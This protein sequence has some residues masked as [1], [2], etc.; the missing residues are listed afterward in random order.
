MRLWRSDEGP[1]RTAAR[2]AIPL[3]TLLTRESRKRTGSR[4]G[5]SVSEDQLGFA[6]RQPSP[7]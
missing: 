7:D 1:N 4:E 2:M 6:R 3:L 5:A